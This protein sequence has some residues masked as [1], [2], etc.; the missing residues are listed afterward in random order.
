MSVARRILVADDDPKTLKVLEHALT[1]EG[2]AVIKA[3]DGQEALDLALSQRPDLVILDVMMPK[4]D[5]FA[6]CGRIRAASAVPILLL[7]ARGDSVD[8]VVGFRLGADDYVTKPF[9]LNELVLRVH[10]ILRRMP[11]LPES[12]TLRF[13]HLEINKST[14][15]VQVGDRSPELTPREFDLLW[16]MASHPGHPFTR[17]SLLARVWHG[18]APTDQSTVTVC[19]RRLRE[20]IEDNPAQP[21]WIKTVWG[22]GYKFDPAGAE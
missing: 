22:I 5:G 17:E 6:V 3:S 20:K 7:T 1:A 18:D 21:R 10:A 2:F 15:T 19:I 14:R 13:G 16:L 9:D 11:T 8:K 12:R 4:V